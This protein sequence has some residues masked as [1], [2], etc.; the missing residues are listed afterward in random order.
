MPRSYKERLD[1]GG[2]IELLVQGMGALAAT[3]LGPLLGLDDKALGT[4]DTASREYGELVEFPETIAEALAPLGWI[5]FDGAPAEEYREAARLASNGDADGAEN[6]LTATW[7]DGARLR[8]ALA[9]R[10]NLYG[11][12]EDADA[13]DHHRVSLMLEALES[14]EDKRYASAIALV[15]TQIDGI[16]YDMTGKDAKSFF[17]AR[18]KATHLQDE[19]T[20]AGHPAGLPV[21]AGLFTRD[22]RTTTVEGQLIRHGIVHGRELAYGTLQNSTKAFVALLAVLE[23]AKPIATKQN[24]QRK[25]AHEER[26]TGSDERDDYG[27]R[28]DRRGFDDVQSTLQRL[29]GWQLGHWKR[30]GRYAMKLEEL[31]PD[32]KY[33]TA[34]G[35]A[36]R[37]DPDKEAY[38]A[39]APTPPGIVF[40]IAGQKGETIPWRYVGETP[41]PLDVGSPEWRHDL[42]GDPYD[43]W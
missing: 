15:L 2:E 32:G 1:P 8:S 19:E 33:L 42:D 22:R 23:W 13:I 35:L 27:R 37:A 43:D 29:E 20:M 31:D 4:L 11:G 39:W 14:H 38:T 26:Y 41:P 18:G 10:R 40:G 12:D 16:V 6:A 28:M 21:L 36:L 25:H 9:R 7:N 5:A 24:E 30:C 34:K 17:A 3:P